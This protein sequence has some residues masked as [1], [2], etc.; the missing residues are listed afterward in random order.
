LRNPIKAID[1]KMLKGPGRRRAAPSGL[2]P[3]RPLPVPTVDEKNHPE[4][5]ALAPFLQLV[6]VGVSQPGEIE[7]AFSAIARGHADALSLVA[8]AMLGVEQKRIIALS[9][10]GRLP[11][12]YPWRTAVEA[13]GLMSYQVDGLALRAAPLPTSTRSSRAPSP[14]TCPWSSRPSSRG[15]PDTSPLESLT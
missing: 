3:L 10:K 5:L 14:A 8:D 13:G 2:V 4:A 7:S 1:W 9:A 15:M 11:T 6:P 12:M